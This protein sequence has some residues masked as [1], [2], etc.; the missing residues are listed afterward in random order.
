MTYSVIAAG[1]SNTDQGDHRSVL[2][3]FVYMATNTNPRAGIFPSPNNPA[4]ISDSDLMQAGINPF[5]AVVP[6][7]GAIGY[8]IVSVNETK[9]VDFDPGEAGVTRDDRIILRVYD[10]MYD[11]SGL[12][13]ARVEYL[14]GTPGGDA[15]TLPARSILLWQVPVPSGA[16]EGG[17]GISFTSIAEDQRVY[18]VSSGGILPIL[19]SGGL[20]SNHHAGMAAFAST[21]KALYISDGTSFDVVGSAGAW[22][23]FTPN[24]YSTLAETATVVSST[25]SYAKYLKVGR[26]VHA[27]V[28]VLANAASTGGGGISLP[29]A[30][31]SALPMIG[32]IRI[33]GTSIAGP[34]A[35]VRTA[36]GNIIIPLQSASGTSAQNFASGDYISYSVT[37]EAAS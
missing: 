33:E 18:T 29:F 20:P 31:A 9:Y 3:S 26:T 7:S 12:S 24:L 37:Y 32:V 21:E 19:T 5:R 23:S 10:D 6:N 17:G 15:S 28:R 11:S 35:G 4:G 36:G 1:N 25:V 2:N 14:K 8:Y 22:T 13:E 16:S 27:N 30:A 34:Y